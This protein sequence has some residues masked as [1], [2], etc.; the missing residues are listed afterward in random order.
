MSIPFIDERVIYRGT[1]YLRKLNEKELK[2]LERVIAIQDRNYDPIVAIVPIKIYL[3]LKEL[4]DELD[5]EN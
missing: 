1:S 5:E 2:N 3:K 4:L